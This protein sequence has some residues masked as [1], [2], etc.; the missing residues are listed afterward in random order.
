M[1]WNVQNEAD[2]KCTLFIWSPVWYYPR[3]SCITQRKDKGNL[4]KQDDNTVLLKLTFYTWW[5]VTH[6]FVLHSHMVQSCLN[7]DWAWRTRRG[8]NIKHDT[9]QCSSAWRT[10][11]CRMRKLFNSCSFKSI[12]F[13]MVFNLLI[14]SL[15]TLSDVITIDKTGENFRLI[16][17]VKGRFIIHRISNDEA[18]VDHLVIVFFE[19]EEKFKPS[20]QW[21]CQQNISESL[22]VYCGCQVGSGTRHHQTSVQ[23]LVGTHKF[24][25]IFCTVSGF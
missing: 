4:L 22:N 6:N 16:Y 20:Y 15:C 24:I 19:L 2:S 23:L 14:H 12:H 13:I 7:P 21:F 5:L 11:R 8:F 17:D 18:K 25:L 9:L 1:H 3:H 10:H